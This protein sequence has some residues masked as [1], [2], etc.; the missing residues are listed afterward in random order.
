[1][2]HDPFERLYN[3]NFGLPNKLRRKIIDEAALSSVKLAAAENKV[4]PGTVYAWRKH[5]R[6]YETGYMDA[7]IE[8][9]G[10]SK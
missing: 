7:S 4:S 9:K 5:I 2:K 8:T 10:G 1:M 3:R 6:A